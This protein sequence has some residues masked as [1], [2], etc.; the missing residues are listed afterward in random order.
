MK[1]KLESARIPAKMVERTGR[2]PASPK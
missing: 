2:P 1:S